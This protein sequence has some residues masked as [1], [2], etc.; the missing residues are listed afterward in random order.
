MDMRREHRRRVLAREVAW[1]AVV[2]GV[3]MLAVGMGCLAAAAN[4]WVASAFAGAVVT[5]GV[6]GGH[7]LITRH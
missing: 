3:A 5:A 6:K 2:S 4:S 7:Y 1:L